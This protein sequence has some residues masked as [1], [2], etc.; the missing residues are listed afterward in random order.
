ML[1]FGSNPE[2]LKKRALHKLEIELKALSPSMLKNRNILPPFAEGL[3]VLNQSCKPL[4]KILDETLLNS[5]RNVAAGYVDML[6]STGFTS[7][8]CLTIKALQFEN[9]KEAIANAENEKKEIDRQRNSLEKVIKDMN[10]SAQM[11]QIE[12][13]ITRLFQLHDICAF[14]YT[15]FIQAFAPDFT[16]AVQAGTAY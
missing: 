3:F 1:F 14:D 16:G 8:D 6:I 11:Q 5:T 13:V 12:I 10:S 9:R 2:S 4:I 7:E 15:K